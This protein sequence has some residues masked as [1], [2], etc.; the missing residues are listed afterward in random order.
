MRKR[1]DHN[2]AYNWAGIPNVGG[3]F[4]KTLGII[5]LGEVGSIAAGMARAF[6]MRVLYL[7]RNRLPAAQEEKLGVEY[8]DL[9]RLLAESDFVSLHAPLLQRMVLLR[10][11][12]PAA[13]AFHDFIAGPEARRIFAAHGFGAPPGA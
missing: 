11:A 7:N 3:L 9:P 2:V 6:G 4:N 10:D 5:G 12:R 1:P 8:A 13:V